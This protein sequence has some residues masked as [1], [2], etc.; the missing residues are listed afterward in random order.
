MPG[1]GETASQ[2]VGHRVDGD[3]TREDTFLVIGHGKLR[4]GLREH[5]AMLRVRTARAGLRARR[6]CLSS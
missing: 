6:G 1:S 4:R 2:L 3:E 5:V